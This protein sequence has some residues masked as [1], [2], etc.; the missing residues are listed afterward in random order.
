[1]SNHIAESTGITCS[2]QQH[3]EFLQTIKNSSLFAMEHHG[4]LQGEEVLP[5][6]LESGPFSQLN[7]FFLDRKHH[8]IDSQNLDC[9]GIMEQ[10]LRPKC[11]CLH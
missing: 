4:N 6:K 2:S 7:S 11:C 5:F 8:T 9:F 1:M 10:I 3:T